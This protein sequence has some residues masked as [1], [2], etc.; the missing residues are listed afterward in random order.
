MGLRSCVRCS[1]PELSPGKWTWHLEMEM[2]VSLQFTVIENTKKIINSVNYN[3]LEN[4]EP[5]MTS[6][7]LNQL[8]IIQCVPFKTKSKNHVQR[9]KFWYQKQVHTFKI[10]SP[11]PSTLFNVTLVARPLRVVC[12]LSSITCLRYLLWTCCV[13]SFNKHKPKKII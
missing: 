4:G 1:K 12:L 3:S 10:Y 8:T 7:A 5:Y 9:H 11:R 6:L 2:S 13:S